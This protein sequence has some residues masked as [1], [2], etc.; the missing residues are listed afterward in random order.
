MSPLLL[1][2]EVAIHALDGKGLVGRD[3]QVVLDH[4]GGE[5]GAVD[6]D[7]FLVRLVALH[8]RAG[9][10][11]EVAGGEEHTLL[12]ALD[13]QR[14]NEVAHRGFAHGFLPALGLQVDGV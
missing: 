13:D 3:T 7:D 9:C 12:H 14:T 6:K 5:A 4:Q 11:S 2:E 8:R 10:G 1:R